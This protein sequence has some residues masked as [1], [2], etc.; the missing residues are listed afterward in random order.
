MN[1]LLILDLYKISK[2]KKCFFK[3]NDSVEILHIKRA[4]RADVHA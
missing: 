3:K 4:G 1:N 2:Y